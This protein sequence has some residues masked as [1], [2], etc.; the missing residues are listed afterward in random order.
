MW[1]A[2]TCRRTRRSAPWPCCPACR[3][4]WPRCT[5]C[6]IVVAQIAKPVVG[7][8]QVRHLIPLDHPFSEVGDG[9]AESRWFRCR[10]SR[11]PRQGHHAV[12][13]NPLHLV[14]ALLNQVLVLAGVLVNRTLDLDGSGSGALLDHAWVLL[15]GPPHTKA[16][17]S[18]AQ[19]KDTRTPITSSYAATHPQRR[20]STHEEAHQLP[21]QPHR[22]S[23]RRH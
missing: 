7:G 3:S 22:R 12:G 5:P 9:V 10:R 2:P 15:G 11:P 20:R 14:Q 19:R 6:G 21:R 17:K 13:A 23:P 18:P 8:A 4:S 16:V 1:A